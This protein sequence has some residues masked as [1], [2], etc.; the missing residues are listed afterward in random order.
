MPAGPEIHFLFYLMQ[1]LPT[2]I[3]WQNIVT[4]LMQS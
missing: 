1:A 2:R 4:N 3:A